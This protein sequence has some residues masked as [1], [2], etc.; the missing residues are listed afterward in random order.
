M[1]KRLDVS[2]VLWYTV[3]GSLYGVSLERHHNKVVVVVV[4]DDDRITPDYYPV[5]LRHHG[6]YLTLPSRYTFDND[7]Y[8][9][10]STIAFSKALER[11]KNYL[12]L[13]SKPRTRPSIRLV[14]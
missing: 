11:L 3:L 1:I 9:T 8:L 12:I 4:G 7:H 13:S 6:E 5:H 14:S 2:V 10:I